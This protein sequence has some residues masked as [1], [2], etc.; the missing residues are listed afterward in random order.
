MRR[1]WPV[2]GSNAILIQKSNFYEAICDSF[3][4]LLAGDLRSAS[5]VWGIQ[6]PLPIR[7][8]CS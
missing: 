3:P 2:P 8:A 7:S 6:L 5:T 1:E 4:D